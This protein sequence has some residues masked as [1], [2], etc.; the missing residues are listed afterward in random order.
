ML[1]HDGNIIPKC[2]Q[3]LRNMTKIENHL[4]EVDVTYL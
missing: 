3:N 1:S 4:Y 2:S